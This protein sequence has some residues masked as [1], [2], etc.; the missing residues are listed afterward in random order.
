[1]A[2]FASEG[3]LS[4]NFQLNLRCD[5]FCPRLLKKSVSALLGFRLQL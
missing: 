5:E 2:E 4:P 3:L 1:M